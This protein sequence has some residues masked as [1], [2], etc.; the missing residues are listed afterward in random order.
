MRKYVAKFSVAQK[1]NFLLKTK[2][3][4]IY[5]VSFVGKKYRKKF[6]AKFNID[7]KSSEK[8]NVLNNTY[9]PFTKEFLNHSGNKSQKW[10]HY[11][12]FYDELILELRNKFG[13]SIKI[14]EIGVQNG[15]SLEI[16][17]KLF[18][19]DAEIHG[20]D[21]DPNCSKFN[22]EFKIHIGSSADRKFLSKV[23]VE[24]SY[25]DLIIDDAS[26]DSRHQRI[27][28]EELFRML[29]PRG[30]Y[31]IEDVENSYRFS[32]KGG[33][34]RPR[35]IIEVSKRIVDLINK[36]FFGS[37]VLRSAKIDSKTVNSIT[38]LK[39]LIVL[40]KGEYCDSK[41]IWTS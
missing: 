9:G 24:A 29:S 2:F 13:S 39:G 23:R 8:E 15:G 30:I 17:R 18:G 14:L 7:F 21:I 10:T 41:I 31:V 1:I 33:Y 35:S 26:H 4:F 38:F 25:F 3:P 5:F 36:D 22:N 34:L 19:P 11:F 27:A 40:R 16:W 28:L 6:D 12:E 32:K 37:P 20:V